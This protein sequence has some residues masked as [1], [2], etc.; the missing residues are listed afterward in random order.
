MGS[1]GGDGRKKKIKKAC[2]IKPNLPQN[3]ASS[4]SKKKK[5]IVVEGM[6]KCKNVRTMSLH[7]S[8]LTKYRC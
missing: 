3:E 8:I 5:P 1:G 4:F 2:F 7:S 6:K